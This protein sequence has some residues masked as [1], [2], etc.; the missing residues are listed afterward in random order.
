MNDDAFRAALQ[1]YPLPQRFGEYVRESA[2]PWRVG[3]TDAA[4][5]EFWR[6]EVQQTQAAL[7]TAFDRFREI[8]PPD[9]WQPG[10]PSNQMGEDE[11]RELGAGW[12]DE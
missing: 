5:R 10:A 9:A 3:V 12:V 7:S 1:N 11:L 4:V 8:N 6:Q 2:L